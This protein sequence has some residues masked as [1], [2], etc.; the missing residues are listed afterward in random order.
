MAPDS[1]ALARRVASAILLPWCAACAYPELHSQ[2][3][4][5]GVDVYEDTVYGASR[6]TF[7]GSDSGLAGPCTGADTGRGGFWIASFDRAAPPV[8]PESEANPDVLVEAAVVGGEWHWWQ[9]DGTLQSGSVTGG[10]V[11]RPV[12]QNHSIGSCGNGVA[13]ISVTL[14]VHQ[15]Y[16][17]SG[18]FEGCM[19]DTQVDTTMPWIVRPPSIRGNLIMNSP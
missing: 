1:N 16:P 17:G 9:A 10:R 4:L 12:D 8:G 5:S 2:T 6:V 3:C 19:D 13:Q 11:M 18:T 14:S 15:Q 7:S